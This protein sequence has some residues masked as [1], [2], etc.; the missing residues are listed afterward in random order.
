MNTTD[1]N[2]NVRD[3]S[4]GAKQLRREGAIPGILYGAGGDNLLVRLD[5]HEFALS[6]IATHRAQ[7]LQLHSEAAA[8]DKVVVLM[9]E[10][11]SHPVNGKPIHIDLLR[12]DLSK[13][14][15]AAVPL[16]FVG[17]AA[18]VV[19]GGLLQPIRRDLEVKALP[20]AL[21]G[22]IEVD[23]TALEIHGS[24]HVSELE[25]EDG[26]EAVYG[27]NFT[28]VTVVPP[29]VEEQPAEEEGEAAEA[30]AAAAVPAEGE[31]TEASDQPG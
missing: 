29:V 25:M 17:K 3:A 8:L 4:T 28:I 9:K 6:G 18:G 20:S 11:Q 22:Q 24:I 19:A 15:V 21:P 26:V 12:L 1:L 27:E 30:D 16:S 23:V 2:I 7:L 13:P 5:A 31:D 14:V 10:V